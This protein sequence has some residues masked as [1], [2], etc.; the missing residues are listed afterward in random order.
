MYDGILQVFDLIKITSDITINSVY[1][2]S[3]TKK[4]ER[5]KETHTHKNITTHNPFTTLSVTTDRHEH[6]SEQQTQR[7]H[8]LT[9][10]AIL[11]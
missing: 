8:A 1:S 10:R 7:A 5:N 6:W 3:R 2:P 11:Q 9:D 4:K